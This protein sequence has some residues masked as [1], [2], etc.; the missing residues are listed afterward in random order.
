MKKLLLLTLLTSALFSKALDVSVSILPQKT[1]LEKIGGDL[2]NINLMVSPGES[3]HS[4]EPKPKQM[5]HLNKSSIYFAIGVEFEHVWLERFRDLNRE[6]RVIDTTKNITKYEITEHHHHHEEHEHHEESD[7]EMD[8]HIWTT[9]KNIIIIS[10]N[11]LEALVAQDPNNEKTYRAN[12]ANYKKE[13]LATHEKIKKLLAPHKEKAFAVLHPSWGY[14]AREYHLEQIA[15]EVNG[16]S[17]KAKDLI[18][19]IKE[20]KKENIKTLFTQPEFSQKSAQT[21]AEAIGGNVVAFSPLHS[22]L[23]KNLYNLGKKI[24]EGF[25]NRKAH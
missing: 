3:P 5:V 15:I 1:I 7:E 13:L 23:Q 17:P 6:M 16:K 10:K 20:L 2:V 25:Q 11:V 19:I 18:R 21:I 9:P 24:D 22:D 4:Y 12:F 8:P 14:F